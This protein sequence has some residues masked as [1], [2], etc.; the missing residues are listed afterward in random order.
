[1]KKEKQTVDPLAQLFR[2]LPEER[3][4]ESFRSRLMEQVM[5]ESAR[6]RR[7]N[8]RLGWVALIAASLVMLT[9]GVLVFIYAKVPTVTI[10]MPEVEFSPF[11]LFLGAM[12]LLLLLFDY[13]L[14]RLYGKKRKEI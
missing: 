6:V 8:A 9:L 10:E 2:Q 11:S 4:P 7:R 13:L 12:G 3:L 5:A 14:R 1:M